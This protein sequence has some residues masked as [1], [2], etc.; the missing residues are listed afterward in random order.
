MLDK[1]LC[2]SA[3]HHEYEAGQSYGEMILRHDPAQ[4]RAHRQLMS[5]FYAAGDRT[6][7]LRQYDRCVAALKQELG[8]PPERRTTNLYERIKTG[9]MG[10]SESAEIDLS[11]SLQAPS[12]PPDVV[13]HLKVCRDSRRGNVAFNATS[14]LLSVEAKRKI[15]TINA[16]L[17][18][19]EPG[20]VATGS[21]GA[22]E[23]GD[24]P[25]RSL[26]PGAATTSIEHGWTLRRRF[27]T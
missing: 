22:L 20:A 23:T 27:H 6:A 11:S 3:E 4:E 7:A 13:R 1:L 14:T 25:G 19:S 5:L 21:R 12:S 24:S 8:V 15:P 26:R 18:V 16:R 2:Y 10:E 17:S 9:Q